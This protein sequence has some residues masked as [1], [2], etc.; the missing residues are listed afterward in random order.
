MR[1]DRALGRALVMATTLLL[2]APGG[3]ATAQDAAGAIEG[4]RT[5]PRALR[6]LLS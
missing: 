6:T 3:R 1:S 5:A 4:V 2:A